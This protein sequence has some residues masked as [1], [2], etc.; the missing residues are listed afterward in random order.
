MSRN[1]YIVTFENGKTVFV[2]TTREEDLETIEKKIMVQHGFTDK[3]KSVTKTTN[4]S[5]MVD[6][7]LCILDA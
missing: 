7:D 5:D 4:I 6:T 1:Y 2:R 3:I